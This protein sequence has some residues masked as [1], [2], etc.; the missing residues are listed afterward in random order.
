MSSQMS[1]GDTGN[2]ISSP[3]L[4]SGVTPCGSPDG[5]T[6]GSAGPA[7]APASR[8]RQ[9]ASG[10]GGRTNGIYSLF[11]RSSFKPAVRPSSSGSRSHPQKLSARSLRL[12]SLSRFGSGSLLELT[13]SPSGLDS[14]SPFT[15]G[16]DGQTSLE[17]N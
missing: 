2:V 8:S 15:T 16:L 12:I 17:E 14:R 7:P 13:R 3:E 4:E 1:L 5:T 6:T 11:G 9:Q 10:K